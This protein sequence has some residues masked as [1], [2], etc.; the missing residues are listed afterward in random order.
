MG[1]VINPDSSGKERTKLTKGIV[2]AIRQLMIQTKPDQNTRDLAAFIVLGLEDIYKSIDISVLAWE[3]RG[4]WVKA[5]RFRIDWEWTLQFSKLLREALVNEDWAQVALMAA[6]TAQKFNHV[7]IS[8]N[9]RIGEPWVGA[10]KNLQK[11]N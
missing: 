6:K 11:K 5:D 3:K 9:N 7:K 1:R 2:K 10:Y 4:Y 8:E